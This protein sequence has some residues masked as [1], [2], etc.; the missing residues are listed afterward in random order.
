MEIT[1]G[2]AQSLAAKLAAMELSEGE[3]AALDAVFNAAGEDEVGGFAL[4]TTKQAAYELR[5]SAVLV[6]NSFGSVIIG[7]GGQEIQRP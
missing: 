5:I 1:E 7:R 4:N 3:R 6:G 2:D